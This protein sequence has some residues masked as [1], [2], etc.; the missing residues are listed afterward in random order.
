[1]NRNLHGAAPTSS[2]IK[3]WLY[4]S[5]VSVLTL[6]IGLLLVRGMLVS[7]GER[8]QSLHEFAASP[9]LFVFRLSLYFFL[10]YFWG[11]LLSLSIKDADPNLVRITRR[12]LVIL[13]VVYEL[14]FA[15]DVI[16][17]L[18]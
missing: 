10:W 12:P 16:N 9:W 6:F 13:L 4:W 7:D 18:V 17:Y 1:M 8:I 2:R 14:L 11:R 3:K 15:S 5:A